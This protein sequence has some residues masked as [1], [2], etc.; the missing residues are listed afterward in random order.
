MPNPGISRDLDTA[1]AEGKRMNFSEESAKRI[2]IERVDDLADTLF[3]INRKLFEFPETRFE[4]FKAAE[5]LTE[6]LEQ[7]GFKMERGVAGL[8][9]SFRASFKESPREVPTIAFMAEYDALPKLGH[10]CGH[11]LIGLGAVGAALALRPMMKE[12]GGTLQV[13]GTP[14]EEGGGGKVILVQ[15]G[16]FDRVEA[17]LMVHPWNITASG[18]N[19]PARVKFDI[20]FRGKSAHSFH[21]QDQGANALAAMIQTFNGINALREHLKPHHSMVHGIITHGGESAHTVPDYSAGSFFI[22]TPDIEYA[23]EVYEKVKHCAVGAALMT[24]TKE[25]FSSYGE[26]KHLMPNLRLAGLFNENLEQLGLAIDEPG[27]YEGVLCSTDA[28]DVSHIVPTIQPY[29]CLNKGFTWHTPEVAQAT[30]SEIGRTLLLNMA[31]V[32]AM[33]AIDL[34]TR[35]D[36]LREVQEEFLSKKR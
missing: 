6:T 12:L 10:A 8:A 35:E 7:D 19:S 36:L 2:A 28:G 17:A 18:A 1:P 29:M 9:T 33:T 3:E 4:E 26:Y 23:R 20:E 15:A 27:W 11:N 30:V 5:W 13:I 34:Y 14:G 24:G 32:L 25:S 16:V 21:N 22:L 31:K